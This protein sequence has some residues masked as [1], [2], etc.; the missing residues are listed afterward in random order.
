VRAF[1]G[2]LLISSVVIGVLTAAGV[3]AV[4]RGIDDRVASIRRIKLQLASAPPQ[5]ANYLIIGSDTRALAGDASQEAGSFGTPQSTPGQRSDTLMVVHVEPAAQ[6]TLVV[7]F[8]RDLVVD[9]PGIGRSKI[10]AAFDNGGP[11]KL[12]DTLRV[13]FG[14]Q[15]SHYVQV[16]FESFQSVVDAIGS[17]GVY[18]PLVT[19]DFDPSP[20][21]GG[22]G[23]EAT[24]PGCVHLS[25]A[26]ALAYVRSRHLQEL[27][28]FADTWIN[29]GEDAPDIYRIWRQQSF[30]RELAGV[31]IQKSLGDP[32]TAIDVAD[33]VLGYLKADSNL[34]RQ[35]VN[36]LIEAFRTLNVNDPTS[37]DFEILPYSVNP[38]NEFGSSL[39][40]QQA[41]AG[42]L[43]ARLESFGD[44]PP[45]PKAVPSQVKVDVV[46]GTARGYDKSTLDAL[47]AQGFVRGT[48][49]SN[50]SLAHA[51]TEVHY[52]PSEV[53]AAELVLDYVGTARLVPDPQVKHVTVILGSSF[54][55]T[56]TVPS[57][58]PTTTASPPATT[59]PAA[60]PVA[61]GPTTTTL[62]TGPPPPGQHVLGSAC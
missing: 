15:I 55:G 16:D 18:F 10:N 44:A 2:R 57:T 36:S 51:V 27:A 9:I 59:A 56:I 62:P 8:P 61:P 49:A 52:N 53:D 30:I 28:P 20:D 34:S 24:T 4:N 37:V 38:S 26:D 40:P 22:S 31:A 17:V 41:A 39:L 11:Q 21:G 33:R 45:P 58:T 5:G 1:F 29:V 19:R 54:T 43:A 50:T 12:I 35:D 46:D 25:G 3:V 32:L 48:S 6:R 13:N 7:S 14:I 23:F 47:A 60:A 42:A